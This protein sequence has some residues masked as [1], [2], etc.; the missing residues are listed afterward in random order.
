MKTHSYLYFKNHAVAMAYFAAACMSTM[1]E[2]TK[3]LEC[4]LGPGTSD[5]RIRVGIHSG[6]VTA[7][8]LRNEKSR[9]QLFGDTMNVASRMEC[10]SSASKI[11]ISQTTADLIA[12]A[13]Y[14]RWIVK[15]TEMVDTKG[16]GQLQVTYQTKRSTR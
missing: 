8:V 7:G 10:S 15:R 2:I 3:S 11:H 1:S 16:K 5:L 13:G 4:V 14:S 12:D 6:P 9:F